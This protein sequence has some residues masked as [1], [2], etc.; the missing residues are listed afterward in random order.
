MM[1]GLCHEQPAWA[2][3]WLAQRDTECGRPAKWRVSQVRG[4]AS[5]LMCGIHARPYRNEAK[6]AREPGWRVEPYPPKVP[7]ET[8]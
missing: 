2:R 6:W 3:G 1:D 4:T 8:P 7:A 5:W